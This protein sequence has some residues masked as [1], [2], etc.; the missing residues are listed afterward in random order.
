MKV[1]LLVL[2]VSIGCNSQS[3]GFPKVATATNDSDS[4]HPNQW[5]I[6]PGTNVGLI[7][8]TSTKVSLEAAYGS[9]NVKHLQ[10]DGPEG[11]T[12]S[13]TVIFPGT[14]NEIEVV[15][16]EDDKLES[17]RIKNSGQWRTKEG[18]RVGISLAEL[19]DING[20]PFFFLGFD[21]DM[22]GG[23]DNWNHGALPGALRVV[24]ETKK[25]TSKI[26]GDTSFRSDSP[27]A[28]EAEIYVAE[29]HNVLMVD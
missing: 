6:V 10:L 27:D 13:G 26:S 19:N 29:I 7:D 9:D 1:L 5:L 18:V 22:G 8:A 24:L 28:L 3:V 2:T 15:W 16:T 17:V 14:S 11:T 21:W 25:D 12:L 20:K 4:S 23:L